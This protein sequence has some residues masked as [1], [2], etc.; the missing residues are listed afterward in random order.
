MIDKSK[1]TNVERPVPLPILTKSTAQIGHIYQWPSGWLR[2][3]QIIRLTEQEAN[4]NALLY[5][6]HW[7]GVDHN[8]ISHGGAFPDGDTL[9]T[10]E[11]WIL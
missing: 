6:D 2:L 10:T 1:A 9:A 7:K 11:N 4:K 8:G 5:L 3:T